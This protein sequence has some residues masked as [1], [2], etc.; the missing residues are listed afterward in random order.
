MNNNNNNQYFQRGGRAGQN[1]IKNTSSKELQKKINLMKKELADKFG[2]NLKKIKNLTTRELDILIT[3]VKNKDNSI[4]E[5]LLKK[6]EVNNLEYNLDE[7]S[8]SS[9]SSDINDND[10]ELLKHEISNHPENKQKI[11]DLVMKLKK[12]NNKKELKLKNI[13]NE[14]KTSIIDKKDK[15][16]NI[17]IINDEKELEKLEN[18]NETNNSIENDDKINETNNSIENDDKINETNNSIENDDKINEINNN[19][20]NDDKINETNN[21]IEINAQDY[22]E[23][24]FYNDYYVELPK[25]YT[26][27]KSIELTNLEFPEASYELKQE[28]NQFKFKLN[29]EEQCFEL[30]PGDYKL[31]EIIESI[32]NGFNELE[33]NLK[34]SLDE[35]NNKTTIEN[36]E[37]KDFELIN[38]GIVKLLGYTKEKYINKSLYV[39]ETSCK[40]YPCTYIYIDTIS[41]DSPIGKISLLNPPKNIKKKFN[42]PIKELKDLIIKFKTRNTKKDELF[43]FRNKPHKMKILCNT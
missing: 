16:K 39:S 43:D 40:I 22:A 41:R 29:D 34:I 15:Y 8:E 26:N 38:D 10:I 36:T 31:D 24:E 3:K 17:K 9:E 37:N 7:S 30:E 11:I 19:I 32:Q 5:Y 12:Q 28:E 21:S 42:E 6:N 27:I 35:E 23:P 2:L 18:N 33:N 1:D 25:T 4:N 13:N 14:I 20:E